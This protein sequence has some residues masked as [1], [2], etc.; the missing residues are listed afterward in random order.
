MSKSLF[1]QSVTTKKFRMN[2]FDLL[3]TGYNCS[4]L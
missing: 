4:L 3:N 1:S 2:A